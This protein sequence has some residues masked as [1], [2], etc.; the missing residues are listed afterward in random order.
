MNF[1]TEAQKEYQN[2]YKL[3]IFSTEYNAF[4]VAPSNK[5]RFLKNT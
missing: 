3:E 4:V 1:K 2:A 5:S